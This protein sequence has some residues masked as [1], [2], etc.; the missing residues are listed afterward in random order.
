MKHKI[1][2]FLAGHGGL[3]GSA[4]LNELINNDYELFYENR[5][6]LDLE[7]Q[8]KTE[9]YLNSIKPNIVINAAG[10]VGGIDDNINYPAEYIY[11]NTIIGLNLIHGAFKAGCK[12]FIQILSNCIYPVD[13]PLPL[14]EMDV[15]GGQLQKTNKSFAQAKQCLMTMCEMYSKQYDLKY[16]SIIPASLYGP[17]DNY[18]NNSSHVMAAIINKL[19]YA[20]IKNLKTV[21]IWGTGKPKREFLYSADLAKACNYILNVKNCPNLLNIGTNKEIEIFKL[22]ELIKKIIGFEGS[23]LF[24]KTKPDGVLSKILNSKKINELGWKHSTNLIDGI[25][26]TYNNFLIHKQ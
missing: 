16:H 9:R 11:K 14:N 24:D 12:Q 3:A 18:D 19:H 4:I 20:K 22:A 15:E 1:K 21:K 8:N 17:N 23:I 2:I 6:N 10:K 5:K 26:K 13:A 25:E 7:D